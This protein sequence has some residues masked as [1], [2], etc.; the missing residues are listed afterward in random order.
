MSLTLAPRTDQLVDAASL[1]DSLDRIGAG[2]KEGRRAIVEVLKR[3]LAEGRAQA[4]E[5]LDRDGRGTLCA[6]RLSNLMDEIVRAVFRHATTHL[7]P[8]DNPTKSER[9]A[10]AA[11]GGYGRGTLAPGSD[12]D[13]LFLHPYKQTAWGESVV[14]TVLYTLWDL[15]LKVGHATRS[16]DECIR[17][18]RSD[19]TIRTAVLEAR[20]ITGDEALV[21]ELM[22]RFD[23]EIVEGTTAEFVA[24]KL[25]ERDERI[26]K[27]G[28]SRYLVEPNVKDGK[29][30]LRDL[31]TLFWIAKYA[32]RV[33]DVA[34]L[35]RA[36]LFSA[37]E[38]R[39]FRRCEDFLW[40]VRCQLHFLAGRAEE[41]LSFEIQRD[42]ALKLGYTA[43]PGLR[44]VER[45]MKHY[46]L[47]AKDVGDLTAIL[48]AALEVREAKSRPMLDRFLKTFRRARPK[49]EL[50]D[51][52]DFIVEND[53]LTVRDQD[54]FTRDPVNLIRFFQVADRNR[55]AL[56]PD[57]KRLVTRSLK[58]VDKDLRQDPEANRLF[59][60]ILTSR[61]SPETVLRHMNEAG[62]LGRFIPEFGRV[63]AM[64]QFNMYHH[65]TVDE[66]L[67]RAIGVLAEIDRGELADQHPLAN[68]VM[69]TISN[70]A[71]LYVALLLH[72]IAKGRP[73]DHSLAGKRI[74]YDLCPRLG[75]SPADTEQVAW[76]VEHHLLMSITAQSR[77]LSDRKTI[78]DFANVV[79][80]LERLKMLLVLTIADIKAVGPG[81]WNGWKGQ[82]LRT[83]YWET[84]LV[85]AGGHSTANR[86]TRVRESQD[87]LRARLKDWPADQVD[88]YLTRHYPAYWLRVDIDRRVQHAE[89][90]RQAAAEGK[91][92]ATRVST[93]AFRGFTELTVLAPDH[94]RLLSMIAG[95]CAAAGAS[96]VD[97][98]I[99]TTSDGLALDTIFI[100]RAFDIDE[101]EVRRAE[102]IAAGIEKALR[103]E[104]RLP[105]V[106][107][108]RAAQST[109]RSRAR[110]FEL[111]PHVLVTNS[112]S[113]RHTVIEVSGLDRPGLLYELTS[114]ISNLS[115]NIASA[116]VATFGE[117]AVDVFYVTDLCADKV[118]NTNRQNAIKRTLEGVLG[119]DAAPAAAAK[120]AGTAT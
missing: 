75:F 77:D 114:A 62:V 23:R 107:A 85:L 19:M 64:M 11:V 37:E 81:V 27:Q 113:D 118:T 112:W 95:T 15:G 40:A 90:L 84:E 9:L 3:T 2:G 93:D 96:I 117:R 116:H 7:Y 38:L 31:N 91:A 46:F 6:E 108:R 55:L 89:F 41:R 83:L 8:T 30:G 98:H 45:F 105:D 79:Q 115:L 110:A 36:G 78:E 100:R 5:L 70:R 13:L 67:I 4:R 76:L 66:H 69:P 44:D 102:R 50:S 17:L 88:A 68:E 52:P 35:V 59:M 47:V 53:R 71:V 54:A 28:S 65:Y 101:D 16:L 106:I 22:T 1:A 72:D 99:N 39:L 97:A 61:N 26:R 60:E 94:P 56:H 34:D 42:I 87:E 86:A 20:Y 25:A 82:L 12:V 104:V 57:A 48:C 51:A 58:L 29:G 49:I 33:R 109:S 103:G 63:V 119:A 14:E 111:E 10:V 21:D 74:A 24:A 73:E 92:M 43:H 120:R 18:A 32:Y 80:S